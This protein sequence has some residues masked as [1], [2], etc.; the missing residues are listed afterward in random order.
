[1][2]VCKVGARLESTCE[3]GV[4][5][6]FPAPR[7][8]P[9]L[10]VCPPALGPRGQ[11]WGG[12]SADPQ[13]AV[14]AQ[15]IVEPRGQRLPRAAL[16]ALHPGC[17]QA[18]SEAWAGEPGKC[19]TLKNGPSQLIR[20]QQRGPAPWAAGKRRKPWCEITEDLKGQ[21]CIPAPCCLLPGGAR[22]SRTAVWLVVGAPASGTPVGPGCVQ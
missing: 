16:W 1:M 22:P 20:R 7:G 9:L 6:G 12:F 15:G 17:Y 21:F 19:L 3:G 10:P 5:P 2:L 4:G 11:R 13:R 8:L 14:R 18:V